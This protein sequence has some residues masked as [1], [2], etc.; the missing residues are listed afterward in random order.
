[1]KKIILGLL[2]FTTGGIAIAQTTL[3]SYYP[4]A[5]TTVDLSAKKEEALKRQNALFVQKQRTPG[6][7]VE[8]EE[9]I[10]TYGETTE[11]VWYVIGG[12]CSWYCGGG[13]YKVVA[14]STL[15]SGLGTTYTAGKANDLSYKTAW[16]EGEKGAGIGAYLEYYFKNKSPRITHIIIAN[17]YQKSADAWRHNNRVAQLRLLVNG[18][19]AGILNLQDSKTDQTFEVGT[20]GHNKD[21]SD[22]ILKFEIAAVYPGEKYDDTAITEIYFEGIDVH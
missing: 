10:K 18:K 14:S 21:G 9:L 22:L 4:T 11:S 5:V 13:N 15:K 12:G 6:E 17:G 1:V 20:L 2:L 7:D 3:K 8:L 19:P 16:V